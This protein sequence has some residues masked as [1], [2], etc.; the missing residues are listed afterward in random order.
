[1]RRDDCGLMLRVLHISMC[2]KYGQMTQN[3]SE[4]YILSL[5]VHEDVGWAIMAL[6]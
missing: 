2:L 4:Y 1:M 5:G 3:I 6:C